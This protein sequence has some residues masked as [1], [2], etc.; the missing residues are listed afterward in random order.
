MAAFNILE[1]TI[2]DIHGAYRSGAMTCRELVQAYLDRIAKFDK[3]GPTINALITVNSAALGEAE[4]LDA[5][6]KASGP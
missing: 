1:A 4:R 5:A 3:H 2:D 6:Y